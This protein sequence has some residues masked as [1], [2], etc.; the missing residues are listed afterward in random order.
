MKKIHWGIIGLGWI[1]GDFSQALVD[2]GIGVYAFASEKPG[3]AEEWKE[4]FGAK[5]AYTS[6]VE[7]MEDPEVDVVYIAT[8]HSNHYE[9]AMEA[10]KR[11]KN[12]LVE[13]AITVCSEQLEEMKALAQEKGVKVFEAQTIYHMPLYDKLHEIVDSGKLGPVKMIQVNFGSCK[14]YDVKNRFFNQ[15]LAGGALLDIGVYA[16]SFV[17]PFLSCQPDEILTTVKRFETGVDESS[18]IILKNSADEMAVVALT[19][20]AKQPKRGV[21]ACE[22]GFIQVENYP[23]ADKATVTW[24]ADGRTETISA[25]E[26]AKAL[27]YEAEYVNAVLNGEIEDKT[28][29]YTTDVMEIMTKVRRTWG[30]TF[31]FE[32]EDR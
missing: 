27:S 32:R 20:R 17:R 11:G 18:G 19:M 5:K 23:R 9:W 25:G 2:C 24:T 30:I 10:L 29:V 31:P 1:G 12:I 26:T 21:I 7:L 15:D 16:L 22:H 4:R 13:K 14:E 8:P 3:K 28:L 6:Y